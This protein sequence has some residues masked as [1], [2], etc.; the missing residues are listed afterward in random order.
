MKDFFDPFAM[1]FGGVPILMGIYGLITN[2]E[3]WFSYFLIFG[4][5]WV[6]WWWIRGDVVGQVEKEES[7][8]AQTHGTSWLD[9]Q[10]LG[11]RNTSNVLTED[12]TKPD[13]EASTTGERGDVKYC[14]HCGTKHTKDAKFCSSC[15]KSF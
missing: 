6:W 8:P 1:I 2:G 13:E 15:G 14:R 5:A 9:E 11:K 7:P 4:G 3:Q 12:D 10:L